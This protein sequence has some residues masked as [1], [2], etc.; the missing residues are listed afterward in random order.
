M[1]R[2][3]IQNTWCTVAT[4]YRTENPFAHRPGERSRRTSG[5]KGLGRLSAARLGS[6]LV[7]VTQTEHGECW[8]VQVDWDALSRCETLDKCV[9]TISPNK[10]RPFK[11]SGTL[12]R[13]TPLRGLE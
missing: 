10:E 3:L 13:I 1:T 6:Q 5:A 7:M 9:V 8:T 12:L 2:D 4:P 11:K